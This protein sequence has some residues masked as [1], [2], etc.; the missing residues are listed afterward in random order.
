[1]ERLDVTQALGGSALIN[2]T[3]RAEAA[4][5]RPFL[6][7]VALC[8]DQPVRYE[9]NGHLAVGVH[10]EMRMERDKGPR[11][12]RPVRYGSK[13]VRVGLDEHVA[14][15]DGPDAF[16]I[17]IPEVRRVGGTGPVDGN[18]YSLAVRDFMEVQR[19]CLLE[20]GEVH[21]HM[22]ACGHG[23][24]L[25]SAEERLGEAFRE[26]RY[27]CAGNRWPCC[28]RARRQDGGAEQR[29]QSEAE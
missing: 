27:R 19:P 9:L 11:P 15:L 5:P 12:I 1:M 8:A 14:V 7:P 24:E 13:V 23:V 18:R 3:T 2:A 16:R 26:R 22:A 20:E 4:R 28:A 21:D 29:G 6:M 17:A 10:G 25:A